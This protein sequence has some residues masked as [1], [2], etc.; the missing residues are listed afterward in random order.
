MTRA[1]PLVAMALTALACGGGG[2]GA[3]APSTDDA[4]A[5]ARTAPTPPVRGHMLG[6]A[7]GSMVG[8]F[9][10][11][12]PDGRGALAAWV[13]AA[14]GQGRRVVGKP[15]SATAEPRGGEKTIAHVPVDTNMLVV[16]P[17]RGAAPGY[18]VAFTSLVD[19][20]ESLTVVAV[21]DDGSPRGKPTELARTTD[22]VVWVD[23]VPTDRG[24]VCVWAEETRG[25]DAHVVAAS[26]DTDGKVR[27]VPARVAQNVSGWH[28]LEIPGGVGV[29]TVATAPKA[30]G[31]ALTLHKLDAEGHAAGAP[32]AVVTKPVVSGDVEVVHHDKRLLF[33]WTDRTADEPALSIAALADDGAIEPPRHAVE[34]RGGAALLGLAA[35]P[36]GAGLLWESPVRRG[37]VEL[38]NVHVARIGADL[39]PDGRPSSFEI[40]GRGAPE[41]AATA[42]GFAIA[43]PMRDCDAGAK[44]ACPDAPVVASL[45]RVDAS[46]GLVQR[47]PLS[48]SGDP[49]SM[50]W[51]LTCGGDAC[52]TLSASGGSPARVRAV[53][54]NP[55]TNVRRAAPAPAAPEVPKD[56]P[57][58]ADV[59]AIVS[60]ESVVD[61]AIAHLG[62]ARLLATLSSKPEPPPAKG[63]PVAAGG[64]GLVLTTRVLDAAGTPAPVVLST[65]ALAV[66]GVAVAAADKPEDG[67]VVAWVARENGD[68]EVH[69]TRVDRKGKRTNDVQLTT[70]KGDASDVAVAWAGGGWIVA[71]VDGRDGN[72]EVYAT[73]VGLDLNRIAR[74][75][76]ITSAPGDASDLVA[77]PKGDA[78]WLAWADPRESPKD[79]MADV[80]VTAVKM[81]DAKRMLDE[82]RL[83]STA[84]HSRSPHLASTGAATDGV[85]VAWIEEAAVG[86]DSRSSSGH[87]ALWVTLDG[88]GKPTAK[89]VKLPLGGDGAASSVAIESTPTGG[90]RGVVARGTGDAIALDAVELGASPRASPL[91]MLDGPPSLDVALVVDGDDVF[92]NDDGPSAADKRARRARIA[93]TR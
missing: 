1:A 19:R 20:G 4:T 43:A 78:V 27:G 13:T 16:R 81:R 22:D 45:A 53:A 28:A 25:G 48:F 69:V 54:V 66:G 9:M 30:K 14:E 55:R 8:P 74:E 15:L 46:L 67:G 86:I 24:A 62:E 32:V 77:L 42:T 23:V 57:R 31:G 51:G 12:H 58:V 79:G 33:A 93:W 83:L 5:P 34:G 89:P 82:T 73:K 90:L 3:K 47:E 65:R 85:H 18:V 68:P 92:F 71:W 38:R 11:R 35:G 63:A 29:S 72:G 49:A 87:G 17:M 60:G 52:F 2:Q 76:R 61:L 70:T 56:G 44:G 75:E 37:A 36:A 59:A 10:S 64:A 88:K 50:S 80:Y 39:A 91:L 6:T 40:V 41:L 7:V 26:L 84:P 21:G